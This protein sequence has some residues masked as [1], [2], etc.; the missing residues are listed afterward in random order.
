MFFHPTYRTIHQENSINCGSC[1]VHVVVV[2]KFVMVV[3][4]A[5]VVVVTVLV[6][7]VVASYAMVVRSGHALG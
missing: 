3:D 6:V 2:V 7:V 4:G 5:S 1:M